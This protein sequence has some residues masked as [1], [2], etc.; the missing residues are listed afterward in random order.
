MES[1]MVR[2]IFLLLIFKKSCQKRIVHPTHRDNLFFLSGWGL[3]K[4][5]HGDVFEGLFENDTKTDTGIYT[6]ANGEI[7]AGNIVK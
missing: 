7:K 1:N 4:W 6:W 5:E 2:P 3:Y